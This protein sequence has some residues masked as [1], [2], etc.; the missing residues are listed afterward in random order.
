MLNKMNRI[1]VVSPLPVP[2]KSDSQNLITVQVLMIK[3][4]QSSSQSVW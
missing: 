4:I 2:V 3:R 1:L